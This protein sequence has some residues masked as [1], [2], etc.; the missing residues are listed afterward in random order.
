MVTRNIRLTCN[1]LVVADTTS[2][3]L[4]QS[5]YE[6]PITD[7]AK[8]EAGVRAQIR[9]FE[10]DNIQEYYDTSVKGYVTLAN[11]SSQYKYTD[12]VYAAYATY[13]M[14]LKELQL[15]GWIAC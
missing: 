6:N 2:L 3:L 14:K 11:I 10:N 15:P 5:D 4:L 7:K 12:Q 8:I 9:N 1:A 13:S